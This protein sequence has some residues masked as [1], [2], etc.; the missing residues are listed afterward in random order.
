MPTTP[1]QYTMLAYLPGTMKVCVKDATGQVGYLEAD[2]GE[3]HPM[4]PLF[5]E[6]AV[7]KYGYHAVTPQ[8]LSPEDIAST[9]RTLNAQQRS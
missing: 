2:T 7:Y 6:A 3:F 5:F 8:P 9:V 4:F 1:I